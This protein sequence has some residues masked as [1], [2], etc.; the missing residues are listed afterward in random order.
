MVE[1][2]KGEPIHILTLLNY[3]NA[4]CFKLKWT[5]WFTSL[6]YTVTF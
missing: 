3:Y 2:D 6:M 1:R 4:D 5:D